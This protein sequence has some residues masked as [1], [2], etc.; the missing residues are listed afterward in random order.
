MYK[1]R[2]IVIYGIMRKSNRELLALY[3]AVEAKF[4]EYKNRIKSYENKFESDKKDNNY[5]V[6][7]G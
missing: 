7:N 3:N 2:P 5:K 1:E 4:R 6:L